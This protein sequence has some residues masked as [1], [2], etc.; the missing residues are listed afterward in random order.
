MAITIT[1]ACLTGM[2]IGAT[3]W[4]FLQARQAVR[5]AQAQR[6]GILE[7]VQSMLNTQ[8]I[9]NSAIAELENEALRQQFADHV[10]KELN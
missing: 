3:V 4:L 2:N 9:Q 8:S 7:L 6:I 1:L 5:Y 10:P